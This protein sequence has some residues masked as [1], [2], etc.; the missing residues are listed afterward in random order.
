MAPRLV[1]INA[2]P[3]E[4]QVPMPI[5]RFIDFTDWLRRDPLSTVGTPALL[6]CRPPAGR[7]D[8]ANGVPTNVNPNRGY[9]PGQAGISSPDAVASP[10]GWRPTDHR[11]ID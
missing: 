5:H 8:S 4:P 11:G 6:L 10:G 3:I 1:P 2:R 9:L 7:W